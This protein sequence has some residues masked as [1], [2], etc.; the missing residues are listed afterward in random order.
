MVDPAGAEHDG[1][2]TTS[3]PE[4]P[5]QGPAPQGPRVSREEITDLGR[6]RR[7]RRDSKVA[8]V[9]GGLARHLDID[10]VILRVAFVVLAFF[11]GAGIILYA[12]VWVLVPRDGS[13][14][15]RIRLDPRSRT[16]AL[17]LVGAIAVLAVLGDSLGGW[18][19]PWP[20]VIIGAIALLVVHTRRASDA[21]TA[22]ATPPNPRQR[23]PLLF[24]FT[25][26]L[27]ALAVGLLGVVDLAG[28]DVTSSAYPALALGITGTM[29]LVGAFFGRAGGLILVGLLLAL[30]T[31][32][33]AA[34]ERADFADVGLVPLNSA[35]LADSY[36]YDVADLEFDLTRL[37]DP[38]ALDGRTLDLDLNFGEAT[39]IVPDDIN[40][41]VEVT[42]DWFG[43][44]EL[45]GEQREGSHGVVFTGSHDALDPDAPT[46]TIKARAGVGE[47]TV[48][49]EEG[50][51]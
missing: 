5:E 48:I 7:T 26:A 32:G 40:V 15:A 24:W 42:F 43:Q 2:M 25:M 20:L 23:G 47:F 13:D 35:S 9:A 46:L 21:V 12:A 31:A 29:L 4:A 18:G 10:P 34:V 22:E 3:P 1:V 27:I 39:V 30:S 6:L 8:G 17:A 41:R 37:T 28:L 44:S 14:N 51:R 33:A 36:T 16:A 11:G 38:E 45:F 19:F 49:T 50:T